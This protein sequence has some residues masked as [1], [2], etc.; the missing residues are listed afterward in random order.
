MRRDCAG[1][2]ARTLLRQGGDTAV[3]PRL[4]KSAL[5]LRRLLAACLVSI[6]I[7]FGVSGSLAAAPESSTL[8]KA[9]SALPTGRLPRNVLPTHVALAL[10]VGPREARFS[11]E[12]RIDVRVTRPTRT[13][14]LHGSNLR[15]VRA[16]LTP[17]GAAPLALSVTSADPSGVLRLDLARSVPAGRARI[18]IA[19]DAPFGQLQGLQGAR[20]G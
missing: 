4:G 5:N 18:E 8:V 9:T 10:T 7:G 20:R 14:W 17:R 6:S 12:M 13:V 2:E 3:R 11:G 1:A 16:T 15:I 19:F